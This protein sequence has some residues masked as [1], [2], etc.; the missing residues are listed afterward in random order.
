MTMEYTKEK[1]LIFI[2][3]ISA[4]APPPHLPSQSRS[5][6]LKKSAGPQQRILITVIIYFS[7]FFEMHNHITVKGRFFQYTEMCKV[8]QYQPV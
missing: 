3:M 6:Y 8:T 1:I 5:A 4:G 2:I 7:V